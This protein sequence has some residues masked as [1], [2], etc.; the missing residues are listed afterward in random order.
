MK[1]HPLPRLTQADFLAGLIERFP[2][3]EAYLLDEDYGFSIH[4]Q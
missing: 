2:G 1:Q 4:L 3:L